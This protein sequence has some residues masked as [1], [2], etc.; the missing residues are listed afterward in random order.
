MTYKEKFEASEYRAHYQNIATKILREMS[1]LR[2][3]VENSPIAP[4]RWIWELIQNAKDVHQNDGI[5]IILDYQKNGNESYLKFKHNGK[6][7]TA[8]N[9]RFLIEQISTKDRE[10][11]EEGKRKT[12]GKFGTGFLTTHLLSEKVLVN[13]V[14][15]EPELDY[16]SFE[17]ELDRSGFELNEITDAVQ[18]SKDSV[19]DLDEKPVYTEY[20]EGAFNTSFTYSLTD[21]LGLSVAEKGVEDLTNCLPYT[22]VF[23]DKIKSLKIKH[24]RTSYLNVIDEEELDENIKI[25]SVKFKIGVDNDSFDLLEFAVLNKNFTSIAIPIH[26]HNNEITILSIEDN[27]PKLFCDFPLIGTEVFN[28]P[29][30]IN[31]PNFNPTDPR[32]GIFLTTSHRTNPLTEDNK[33]YI[34]EAVELY[35]KLLDFASKDNWENLHLLAQ[36]RPINNCPYWLDD[37]WYNR[38][39]LN[40]IRKK[41][42]MVNIVKTSDGSLQSIHTSDNKKYIWFPSS[43]NQKNRNE[44]WKIA[45][46]WFPYLL[47][48][49]SDVELWTKLIWSECGKL[50]SDQLAL[51]I[52]NEKKTSQEF[53]ENLIGTDIHNWLES[54]YTFIKAEDSEYDS[55]INNRAIFLNQHGQFVKKERLWKDKGNIGDDFKNILTELGNDIRSI[56][57]DEKCSF[58][59]GDERT[60]DVSYAIKEIVSEVNS[61]ANDRDVAKKYK[62]AFKMLLV[63]FQNYPEKSKEL[64]PTLYRNKHLLYDDDE[65]LDNIK[66][67]EELNDLL[68]E[69]NVSDLSQ[70]RDLIGKSHEKSKSL[71]PVTENILVSMG[72]TSIEE[73]KEA[74]EDKNLKELFS[75]ESTPSTDM[76]VYVQSLIERAKQNIIA[77][78]DNLKEYDLKNIDVTTAPTILAGVYKDGKEISI[79][80]RPAYNNE[81]I[82]YY[83]SERDIL[84]FEPS[85]LWIDDGISPRQIT[86]GHILKSANIV[87]FPV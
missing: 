65:I 62:T 3:L 85:E 58:D 80:T 18:K 12:T 81:V 27:V 10:K 23:V 69:F 26:R 9:I 16:R 67:A 21:T 20:E 82:I 19:Q 29:V 53:S 28:F 38:T 44:L 61:K 35:F 50:T 63:W 14:A 39:V 24:T 47:P 13:G 54:F 1:S 68:K 11:D 64:F 66:K 6:P 77:T 60:L 46:A 17:L 72:I 42:L 83:G 5:K 79:V 78:L 56:L 32:D 51:F 7:F 55:I 52:Q 43:T 22:F 87:K 75:H 40:P 57:L 86:L 33:V 8:D 84:D 34:E 37:N 70:I 25:K 74:I 41:L 36:I 31:N 59:L 4:R 73:W 48:Q 2:S 15:K 76:F 71:L 30:V 45:N 49:S